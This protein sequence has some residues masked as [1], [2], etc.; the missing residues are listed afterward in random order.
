MFDVDD[1]ERLRF[2]D[3]APDHEFAGEIDWLADV[4]IITGFPDGTFRPMEPITRQAAAAWL[5]RTQR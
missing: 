3:V 4:G 1:P 2:S 5:E